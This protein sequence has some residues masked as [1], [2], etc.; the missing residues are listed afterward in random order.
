V[1]KRQK[2]APDDETIDKPPVTGGAGE[3]FT[4][5]NEKENEEHA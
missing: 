3:E 1:K 2:T 5:D 4:K